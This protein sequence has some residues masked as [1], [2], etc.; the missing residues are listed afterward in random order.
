MTE[1]DAFIADAERR[2]QIAT[3]DEQ[4]SNVCRDIEARMSVEGADADRQHVY[5][6]VKLKYVRR[7][8]A[9]ARAG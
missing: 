3:T 2:M 9:G 8:Y 1:H 6:A 5:E 4:L 7:I